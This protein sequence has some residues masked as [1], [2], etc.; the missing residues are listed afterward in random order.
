MPRRFLPHWCVFANSYHEFIDNENI[1]VGK[2][3]WC[4]EV[5]DCCNKYAL[6]CIELHDFEKAAEL[7]N[8]ADNVYC[9][10]KKRYPLRTS[11]VARCTSYIA[12]RTS[13]IAH[14]PTFPC[15]C[16]WEP[17]CHGTSSR[18]LLSPLRAHLLLRARRFVIE[19]AQRNY[20]RSKLSRAQ[21]H[22]AVIPRSKDERARADTRRTA[23][24]QLELS[25]V[26]CGDAPRSMV[27][28][29][30][31]IARFV[32]SSIAVT[33]ARSG[34]LRC[35]EPSKED[36]SQLIAAHNGLQYAPCTQLSL[37]TLRCARSTCVL[38]ER[39]AAVSASILRSL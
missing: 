17:P 32:N 20:R 10:L 35:K 36:V 31:G 25:K 11:Q 21:R 33:R 4:R 9:S 16:C 19:P 8:T 3:C 22:S 15:W 39:C 30:K 2:E 26:V 34:L 18:P 12:H 23:D 6:L 5:I 7:L 27:G 1:S 38:R 13:H 29:T 28:P 24:R 37:G 14:A